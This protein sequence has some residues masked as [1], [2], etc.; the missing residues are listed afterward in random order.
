MRLFIF[1]LI[2]PLGLFAQ[3]IPKGVTKIIVTNNLSAEENFDY[4]IKTLLDN[5]YFFEQS[6][7]AIGYIKTQEKAIKP[8]GSIILN[9]RVEKNKITIS[10]TNKSGLDLRVGGVTVNDNAE[11]I[12]N[13]G[14]KGSIVK[15]A[16]EAMNEIASKFNGVKSYN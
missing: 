2:F 1:I 12:R 14:M 3:D 11:P 9:I 6:D 8:S 13:A 5:D 10:G 15:K 4:A 7:K 16:F